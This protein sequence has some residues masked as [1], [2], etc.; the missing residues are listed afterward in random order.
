MIKAIIIPIETGLFGKL[1]VTCLILIS[2]KASDKQLSF[3]LRIGNFSMG[4]SIL[5]FGLV[6]WNPVQ[7]LVQNQW[8]AIIF[9]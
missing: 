5:I 6:Y 9:L 2:Q 1:A 3:S 8:S 4:D 7:S